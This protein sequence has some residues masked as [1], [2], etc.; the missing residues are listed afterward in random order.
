MKPWPTLIALATALLAASGMVLAEPPAPMPKGGPL[1]GPVTYTPPAFPEPPAAGGMLLRLGLATAFVLI[2]CVV[3]MLLAYR[4]AKGSLGKA[5]GGRL[6]LV[7]S[8]SLGGGS[9]LHLIRHAGQRFVVA[10][11][12]SGLHSLTP[13]AESFAETFES[14]GESPLEAPRRAATR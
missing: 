8:F 2:L 13:L 1:S 4:R 6:V 11:N 14:L 3:A 5:G 10:V 7:E 9:A 12:R